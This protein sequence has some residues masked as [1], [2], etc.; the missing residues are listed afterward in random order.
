MKQFSKK[1]KLNMSS[2]IV[3]KNNFIEMELDTKMSQ[4]HFFRYNE[5]KKSA[6]QILNAEPWFLD[7]K[8]GKMILLLKP[9]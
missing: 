8:N 1:E 5:I 7:V 6:K 4:F 3:N 9:I 2:W